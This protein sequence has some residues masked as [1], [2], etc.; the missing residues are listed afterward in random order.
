MVKDAIRRLVLRYF[1]ELGQR[2]H[3]PQLARI[4]RVYDLPGQ[5][6]QISSPFRPHQAADIQLLDAVTRL[7]LDVPVFEQVTLAIGQGHEHGL[8]QHPQPGMCCLIQYI[9][10]LDSIPVI[11]ALLPWG[12]SIPQT[13]NDDIQL[14]Q[15]DQSQ[16]S[17]ANG[18]WQLKTDGAITQ[19]SQIHTRQ[20]QVNLEQHHIRQTQI[21][22]HDTQQIDGNQVNEIMGA[23]KTIVGE[24]AIIAALDNLMLGSEQEMQLK[25]HA[26][27]HLETLQTLEA[28]ATALAK[29]QGATVWLG[30]ENVNAVQVLLDLIGL[31]KDMNTLLA[32]HTHI[33]A[34]LSHQKSKF[35]GYQEKAS[36]LS[37]EVLPITA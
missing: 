27:M 23:L 18:D 24:K 35:E 34:G 19:H 9:D 25:S 4:E 20:S 15:S 2:K 16:L 14:Q 30:S 1:P 33:G 8:Y 17:G 31:V 26:N 32:K 12:M 29:V 37:D 21:A 22:S 5:E 11:T 13:R 7:P 28:K 36:Q 10:G 3:V 6:P